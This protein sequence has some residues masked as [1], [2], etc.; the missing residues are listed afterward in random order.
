M[1]DKLA[2]VD[3][4]VEELLAIPSGLSRKRMIEGLM[5]MRYDDLHYLYGHIQQKLRK[6]HPPITIIRQT[7][8][9]SK[10][11]YQYILMNCATG[12]WLKKPDGTLHIYL[13][14]WRAEQMLKYLTGESK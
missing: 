14:K 4:L 2:L 5:R 10:R 7:H 12:Q 1:S 11:K 6:A 3:E 8:A 13:Q 9:N